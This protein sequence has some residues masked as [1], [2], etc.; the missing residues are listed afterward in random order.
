MEIKCP[1]CQQSITKKD[2]NEE[3]G[4]GLCE[5]CQ[6]HFLLSD[7]SDEND[8]KQSNKKQKKS[9]EELVNDPPK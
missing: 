5:T 9:P 4:Y 7:I 6:N 2:I 3:E 8:E 1:S